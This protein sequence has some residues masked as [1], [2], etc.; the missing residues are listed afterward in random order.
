MPHLFGRF[1]RA[2]N[3]SEQHISGMGI[4]LYVVRE[5]VGLHGGTVTARSQEG[6]GSTFAIRLPL[7]DSDARSA[8]PKAQD[9]ATDDRW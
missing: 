4:G 2:G 6:Q 7:A 9:T 1:F 3:A 8:K 5:I